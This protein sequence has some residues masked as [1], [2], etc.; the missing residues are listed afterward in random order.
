MNTKYSEDRQRSDKEKLPVVI[1]LLRGNDPEDVCK[2]HQVSLEE[3]LIWKDRFLESGRR[4]LG[5]AH[6]IIAIWKKSLRKLLNVYE[7]YRTTHRHFFPLLFSFFLVINI[8]CYWLGVS[9]AFPELLM[10]DNK[11]YYFKIQFPVGILGASFDSLSFFITVYI[12]RRALKTTTM[13]SYIG[14]LSIDL[15]IAIVATGW[16]LF[17]F[18]ISG[19]IIGFTEFEPQVL[20]ER[21][22][23][24]EKLIVEIVKNPGAGLRNIYFGILM[25][26]STIIPTV[27]HIYMSLSSIIRHIRS[28]SR[29]LAASV[30]K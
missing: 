9:T 14:Y 28:E 19:W 24:Y 25:G 3:A 23:T 13:F 15:L 21:T 5:D 2:R 27:I 26:F 12:V 4:S 8:S 22:Q 17:V 16:V 1:E 10:G 29:G 18:W 30:M 20:A 6:P 11:F 7:T